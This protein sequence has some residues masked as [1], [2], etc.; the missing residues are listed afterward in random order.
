M[1]I[2]EAETVAVAVATATAATRTG[3]PRLLK[4][5]AMRVRR[6]FLIID[7][8]NLEEPEA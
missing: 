3:A 6:V 2:A 8:M 5:V 1:A 7:R 4:R